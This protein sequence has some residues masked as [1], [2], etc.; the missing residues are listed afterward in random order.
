VCARSV[1]LFL[2]AFFDITCTAPHLDRMLASPA[3]SRS[4][5][6]NRPPGTRGD[7]NDNDD[8]ASQQQ[9]PLR[10]EE[11][12]EEVARAAAAVSVM[13]G[14]GGRRQRPP[15]IE[16]SNAAIQGTALGDGGEAQAFEVVDEGGELVRVRFHEFLQN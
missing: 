11:D 13:A 2:A 5:S 1:G 8:S 4:G 10:V 14:G 7:D 12:E 6:S 16:A 3:A 15:G 9:Q